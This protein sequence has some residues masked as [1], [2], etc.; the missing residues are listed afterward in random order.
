MYKYLHTTDYNIKDTNNLTLLRALPENAFFE[1]S[2]FFL[3]GDTN[4]VLVEQR[5]KTVDLRGFLCSR[6][7]L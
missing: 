7:I 4:C 2:H 6:L 1:H 3:F 5:W